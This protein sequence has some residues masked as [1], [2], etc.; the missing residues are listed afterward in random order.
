MSEGTACLGLYSSA[1]I[2]LNFLQTILSFALAYKSKALCAFLHYALC[3]LHY[4]LSNIL[5]FE[6]K[7]LL[8]R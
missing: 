2:K 1:D 7:A 6:K 5:N 4:A 3:I 8:L